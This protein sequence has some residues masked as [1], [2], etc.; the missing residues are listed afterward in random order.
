MQFFFFLI[1]KVEKKSVF[2]KHC[3]DYFMSIISTLCFGG[4]D[5]PEPALI[6][7]LVEILYEE[8]NLISFLV[9]NKSN[10]LSGFRSSLLRILMDH[11]QVVSIN[12]KLPFLLQSSCQTYH[13]NFATDFCCEPCNMISKLWL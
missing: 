6:E 1:S 5:T 2:K 9:S 7:L 13:D 12:I 8:D 10:T 11:R 3:L 4:V